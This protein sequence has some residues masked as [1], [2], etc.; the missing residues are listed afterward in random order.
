MPMP[1]RSRRRGFPIAVLVGLEIGHAYIWN[2]YSEAVRPGERIQGDIGYN[3]YE[4]IID[5]LRPSFKQGIK[6]IL[7]GTPDEKDY[8]RFINHI[9][10]HQGWLLGGWRLNTV[11][12][13]RI[14]ERATNRE[15]VRALVRSNDFKKKLAETT[16]GDT[17]Q[18]MEEL[19]KR[20]ND[21]NGIN[22]LLFTLNEVEDALYR[23]ERTP[24]YILATE[25]FLSQHGRRTQ[26][27]FQIA[28]NKNM[29]TSIIGANTP[30]EERLAQLGGLVC[31]LRK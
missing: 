19:E 27:L 30:A 12:F 15:E 23:K 16:S 3:F 29:K 24:E 31:M 1:R 20:M 17:R 5:A 28:A 7:I 6:S 8:N 2:I 4:E 13:N 18:V 26:R 14:P 21:I 10:K 25:R 11:T 9:K 22:T